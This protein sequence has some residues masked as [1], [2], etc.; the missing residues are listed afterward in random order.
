MAQATPASTSAGSSFAALRSPQEILF[1]EGQ[2]AALGWAVRDKGSRAFICADPH[3]ATGQDFAGL[4]G[5]IEGSG[6]RTFVYSDI[7]PELPTAGIESAVELAR[8]FHA[9]V[10]VAIGG[11]SS[12]DLAKVVATLVT[13]GGSLSDYYGEFKVPGPT[14]PVIAVPT[15]AGTGSEVT[16]VAV[17]TDPDRE[18]KVGLSSP[19]LIPAVAICDPEL[20]YTCPPGVTASAG[21]DALAHCVE[22]YTAVRRDPDPRLARDRV[23]VGSGQMTDLLALVGIR[24]IVAGLQRSFTTPADREARSSVMY[25]A[26]MAGLA[27]GTAGTAAAHALQ[28][29][30]GAV[31]HTP[32]GLGVGVLLPYVME[33]N[34]PHRVHQLAEIARLFGGD[35]QTEDQL[36]L[37]AP[38]LVGAYLA[39]IGIPRS[40]RE[41]GLE[42]AHL[43]WTAGQAPKAARLSENNPEPLTEN[44]ARRILDA[45]FAGD[46]ALVHGDRILEGDPA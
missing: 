21:A 13:H 12:I 40:L 22:A 36:A 8:E 5:L 23:F 17:V 15:T 46:L 25:G 3:I 43:E 39:E 31:T 11:G 38:E 26:L 9:D 44:G 7:V 19:H 10:L 33:F 16:P 37:Q 45:S 28:Y 34:R 20:T 29:P 1:G 24:H 42:E 27:F 32:H 41:L 6:V 35:G 2:R 18:S 30:V 14:L 4:I